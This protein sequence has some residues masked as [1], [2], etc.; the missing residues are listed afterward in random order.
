MTEELTEKAKAVA[1][2]YRE[3]LVRFCQELIRRPSMPGEE[4]AVAALMESEMRELGYHEVR[5]DEVGNVIG[6]MKG[7]GGGKSIMLNSHMDHVHPGDEN[8]WPCPPYSGELREGCVWGRGAS[9]TKGAIATQVYSVAALKE[10]V[11]EFPADVYVVGVVLEEMGGL[12]TKTL[13]K[14][15]RTDYAVLGEGTSNHIKIGHRGRVGIVVQVDGVSVHGSVPE[16]GVNP[17]YILASF[18]S[19]LKDCPL[20]QSEIYGRASVAPTLY[21]SDQSSTNVTPGR[22]KLHLD[23]RSIPGEDPK[24][25][26]GRFALMLEE[27]LS[28]GSEAD[29]HIPRFEA[30]CYTGYSEPM[31]SV[32]PSY[33]LE[34]DHPLVAE[35]RACLQQALGKEVNVGKWDFATDGGHLMNAGIPT[36]G[37]SPCQEEFAHTNRD[38]VSVEMMVE[39]VAGYCALIDHLWSLHDA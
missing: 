4:G 28:F 10:L 15:L 32:I 31:D 22:C 1:D 12:G 6:L 23:Y 18:I 39:A 8:S 11:G 5:V 21:V 9:D 27:C 16:K 2:K 7:R 36:I 19:R 29:V 25:V 30:R 37:F 35:A 38:R 14:N 17:H 34:E 20:P 13:V 26:A 33:G 3:S 24:E